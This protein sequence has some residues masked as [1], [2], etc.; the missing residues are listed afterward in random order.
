LPPARP[1]QD[2]AT[3]VLLAAMVMTREVEAE[4]GLAFAL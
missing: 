4:A 1:L 3:R 2:A